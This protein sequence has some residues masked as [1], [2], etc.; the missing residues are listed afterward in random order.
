MSKKVPLYILITTNIIIIILLSV[1]VFNYLFPEKTK[2]V[3]SSDVTVENTKS[4]TNYTAEEIVNLMKEKNTNIGKI[5]VYTEETDLNNLLGRP[6][7]Y[8]SKIQFADNR[9]DQSYVEENDAKGGTIEV[10]GTK[11]DMEKRKDYI[12]TISSSASLFTQYIYS[13][14]YAILRLDVELTPEQAKEYE[15]LFYEV[16]K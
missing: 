3:S 15:N 6:N 1:M 16:I 10:F 8:T 5:V 7:Q 14:G 9:L 12:E 4:T 11:E 13:K 2:K